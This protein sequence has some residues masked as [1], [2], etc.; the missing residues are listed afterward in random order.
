MHRNS[1]AYV[2][3]SLSPQPYFNGVLISKLS[4]FFCLFLISYIIFRNFCSVSGRASLIFLPTHKQCVPTCGSECVS[5]VKSNKNIITIISTNIKLQSLRRR[6]RGRAWFITVSEFVQNH[7][8][9][10][11][12]TIVL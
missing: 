10:T 8:S 3:R 1:Q 12:P 6:A 7:K 2:L 9:L 4:F 11:S 5:T